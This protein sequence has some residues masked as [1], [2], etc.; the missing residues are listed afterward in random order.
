MQKITKCPYCG[1][2]DGMYVKFKANGIDTY[3]FD[4]KME[5][6][7]IMDYFEHKKTMRCLDCNKCIMSYEEFKRDYFAED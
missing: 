1:G 2:D 5:N 3:R 6:S 4:G 7:E